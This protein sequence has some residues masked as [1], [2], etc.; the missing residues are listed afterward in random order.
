LAR[1]ARIAPGIRADHSRGDCLVAK[2]VER[3]H[4]GSNG[5]IL[6]RRPTVACASV[7]Q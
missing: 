4:E 1:V 5:E 6:P 2:G 3:I 7:S